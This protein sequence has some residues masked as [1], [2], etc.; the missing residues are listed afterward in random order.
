[1][2]GRGQPASEAVPSGAGAAAGCVWRARAGAGCTWGDGQGLAAF[3]VQGR[4]LGACGGQEL[5]ACG[6]QVRKA[7]P[8]G[9]GSD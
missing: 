2:R 9:Q 6:V 1:M 7:P 5:S 4:G 8:K 3:G